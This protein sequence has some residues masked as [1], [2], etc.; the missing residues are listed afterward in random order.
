MKEKPMTQNI[1]LPKLL[2]LAEQ[3][4]PTLLEI[5]YIKSLNVDSVADVNDPEYLQT[6]CTI[7]AECLI[8]AIDKGETTFSSESS[9]KTYIWLL[10]I[11]T[12]I[13]AGGKME[14]LFKTTKQRKSRN[15]SV[16]DS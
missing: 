13:A 2:K 16:T 11:L 14:D 15:N 4:S 10:Q 1:F 7:L 8:K 5:K 6:A 12:D 9:R 3:Q